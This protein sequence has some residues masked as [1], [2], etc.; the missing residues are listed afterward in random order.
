[1]DHIKY[2]TDVLWLKPFVD[3]T[4]DLIPLKQLQTVSGFKVTLGKLEQS[5]GNCLKCGRYY[6]ITL[7]TWQ[8]VFSDDKECGHPYAFK[9][10]R[11][12]LSTLLTALAHELAHLRHW[13]HDI[14][15]F[16][17]QSKILR[18]FVRVLKN[19]E[20]TNTYTTR[21]IK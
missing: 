11:V 9:H 5:D 21:R 12:W 3:S 19:K 18:R 17:L 10:K 8:Q 16:E 2:Q 14:K 1:M 7:R 15:H 4:K 6:D 20:V 13:D